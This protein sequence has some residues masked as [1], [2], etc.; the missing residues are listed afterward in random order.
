MTF[1]L[2]PT[3]KGE[4]LELWPL[5][6]EDFRDLYLGVANGVANR[7]AQDSALQVM[8]GRLPAV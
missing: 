4:L 8:V 3:L 7:R 1:D 2:Q 5:R 6:R